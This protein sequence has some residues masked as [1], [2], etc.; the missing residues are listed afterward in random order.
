MILRAGF[1]TFEFHEGREVRFGSNEDAV[2]WLKHLGLPDPDLM[3][4]FRELLGRHS[5]EADTS[6]LTDDQ[7]LERLG[8]LLHTGR[9]A[10][11][12]REQRTS[13]GAP[14]PS[15]APAGPAFPLSER[16]LAASTAFSAPPPANDPPTFSPGLNAAAQAAAL[17]AAAA[18]GK[19]F[20]LE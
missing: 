4:R 6:R 19:P 14:T 20:C 15:T 3:T 17:T 18:D 16:A 11:L 7:V 8:A 2:N 13:S 12:G 1:Q 9:L 5:T 10:V